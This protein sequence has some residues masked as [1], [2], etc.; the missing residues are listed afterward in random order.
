MLCS[1]LL[2]AY[3]LGRESTQP[4]NMCGI[5]LEKAKGCGGTV[6]RMGD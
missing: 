3:K 6:N 5:I 4:K 1:I 2:L